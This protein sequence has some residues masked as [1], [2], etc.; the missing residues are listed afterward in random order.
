MKYFLMIL[1]FSCTRQAFVASTPS[2]LPKD[3]VYNFTAGDTTGVKQY[4]IQ[5]SLSGRWIT[6]GTIKPKG[7]GDYT[8]ILPA[9]PNYY[10]L[11]IVGFTTNYTK[12]IHVTFN[13]STITNA[14][15]K[16]TTLVWT[17]T[18]AINV[19]YFLIEKTSDNKNYTQVTKATFKGNG[20][21]TYR[22]SRTVKK[23]TYRITVIY[24]DGA[25][26]SSITFK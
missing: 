25:K 19:N 18:N 13:N 17:V 4:E 3:Y 22:Y 20:T 24:K 9:T 12:S 8:Y 6:I 11:K 21:Y 14:I 15:K 2:R 5:D 1:L 26:S 23:Y 10:R 7:P 16:T